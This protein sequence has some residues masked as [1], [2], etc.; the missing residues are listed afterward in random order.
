MSDKIMD[1][2]TELKAKGF[3]LTQQI[4]QMDA[5][6]KQFVETNVTPLQQQLAAVQREIA[7]ETEKSKEL[8]AVPDNEPKK[9]I[10]ATTA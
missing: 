7:T 8:E 3:D 2:L 4:L 5:Q 6:I 9:K 1:K 10:K